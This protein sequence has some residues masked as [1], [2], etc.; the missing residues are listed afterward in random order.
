M[1]R[2]VFYLYFNI[3]LEKSATSFFLFFSKKLLKIK[4][5]EEKPEKSTV[6][7]TNSHPVWLFCPII[8]SSRYRSGKLFTPHP[9]IIRPSNPLR[10]L[11]RYP[12]NV[13]QIINNRHTRL[14]H[15]YIH[16][17]LSQSGGCFKNGHYLERWALGGCFWV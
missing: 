2:K 11:Q 17:F 13:S 10:L 4:L 9:I 16:L 12:W 5:K 1:E 3:H 14:D 7:S 8:G 6:V 15:N